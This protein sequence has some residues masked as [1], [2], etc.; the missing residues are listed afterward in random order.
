MFLH[1]G[2]YFLLFFIAFYTFNHAHGGWLKSHSKRNAWLYCAAMGI[3]AEA[4]QS[5]VPGR[6]P[7]FG[8]WIVDVLGASMAILA[9]PFLPFRGLKNP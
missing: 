2:E 4:L 6:M 5:L 3:L 9:L 1:A 8:D 7:E